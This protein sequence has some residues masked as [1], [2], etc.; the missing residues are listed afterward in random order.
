M[1]EQQVR[2]FLAGA[3]P[4]E[5]RAAVVGAGVDLVLDTV[6]A[7]L[8]DRFAPDDGRRA[9]RLRFVLTDGDDR[10]VRALDVGPTGAR[11]GPAGEPRAT[12]TVGLVAFL[13]LGVG[14]ADARRLLMR[15]RLAVSGDLLWAAVVVRALRP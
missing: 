10:H 7:G 3:A 12:I 2:A 8:A 11:V 9:G 4:E 5:I 13:Q 6:F 1:T 15:R 14:A